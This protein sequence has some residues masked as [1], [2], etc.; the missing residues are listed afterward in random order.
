M[1]LSSSSSVQW[2]TFRH[3]SKNTSTLGDRH[4]STRLDFAWDPPLLHPKNRQK[5]GLEVIAHRE[6][7]G[8][9]GGKVAFFVAIFR[10]KLTFSNVFLLKLL[11]S[12]RIQSMETDD[13][14]SIDQSISIDKI[15]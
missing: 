5:R 7:G 13:R 9:G 12:R 10:K 8:G 14:K 1:C 4:Q 3:P 11:I 15:S 2:I 6:G